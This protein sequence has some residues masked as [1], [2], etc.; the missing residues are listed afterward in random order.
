M[1]WQARN[2]DTINTN[3]PHYLQSSQRYLNQV[4]YVDVLL[5]LGKFNTV[6]VNGHYNG[7]NDGK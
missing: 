4:W 3:T 2:A 1:L 7:G 5:V 6:A